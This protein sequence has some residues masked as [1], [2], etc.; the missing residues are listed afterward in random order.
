MRMLLDG[1][2]AVIYS[3]GFIF[4]WAYTALWVRRYDG[5]Q[6]AASRERTLPRV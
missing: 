6:V 4:L 3:T 5:E 2:S 1:I